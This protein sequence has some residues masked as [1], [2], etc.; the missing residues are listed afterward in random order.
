VKANFQRRS[1]FFA[2]PHSVD[3]DG[4]EARKLSVVHCG[5]KWATEVTERAVV[6]KRASDSQFD[7]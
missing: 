3:G 2:I 1:Q 7:K 4:L 6:Y 5:I